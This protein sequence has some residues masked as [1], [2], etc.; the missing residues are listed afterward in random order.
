MAGE[1]ESALT[2]CRVEAISVAGR[3]TVALSGG[4]VV[5]AAN[6]FRL[7]TATEV[8]HFYPRLALGPSGALSALVGARVIG[9]GVTRAGGLELDF[10]AAGQLSVP[11]DTGGPA[12]AE[13]W[14]VAGPHG[15]LFTAEPGG[16]LAV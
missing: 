8:E 14:R 11:P 2:G 15:P 9:A 16:Y 1:I 12:G 3:L 5:T 6:D 4:V 10:G 7:R 13:A